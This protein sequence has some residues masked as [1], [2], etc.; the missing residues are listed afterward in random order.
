MKLM[1]F[2]VVRQRP[3]LHT[4]SGTQLS[5][6]R[7]WES[8]HGGLQRTLLTKHQHLEPTAGDYSK[9]QRPFAFCQDEDARIQEQSVRPNFCCLRSFFGRVIE[10]QFH[11]LSIVE[12][13][14]ILL[15]L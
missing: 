14:Y 13:N 1:I 9:S 8:N 7:N 12:P 5:T 4:I 2:T 10:Q 11:I 6:R 3:A 15:V